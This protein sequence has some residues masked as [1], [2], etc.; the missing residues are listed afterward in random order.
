MRQRNTFAATDHMDMTRRPSNVVAVGVGNE[1]QN[2]GL[3]ETYGFRCFRVFLVKRA[4][5][6]S[7]ILFRLAGD[8][9]GDD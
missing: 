1:H 8:R 5:L 2:S 3:H 6:G 4:S 7:C 9:L